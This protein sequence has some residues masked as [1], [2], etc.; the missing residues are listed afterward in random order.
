MTDEIMSK[1]IEIEGWRISVQEPIKGDKATLAE[2]KRLQDVDVV[3]LEVVDT[4]DYG[5]DPY[6]RTGTFCVPNFEED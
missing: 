4:D 1:Q 2:S 3:S 5:A 6:N